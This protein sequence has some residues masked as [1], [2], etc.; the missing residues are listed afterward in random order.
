MIRINCADRYGEKSYKQNVDRLGNTTD[1]RNNDIFKELLEL[2]CQECSDFVA[3]AIIDG[4]NL[5]EDHVDKYYNQCNNFEDFLN[6]FTPDELKKAFDVLAV[7]TDFQD[8]CMQYGLAKGFLFDQI[9]NKYTGNTPTS[10]HIPG[11][12]TLSER[13]EIK[14]LLSENC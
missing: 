11:L 9:V 13:N 14:K 2:C 6:K 10:W 3:Q 5:P 8:I 12:E 7:E 1:N 4:N